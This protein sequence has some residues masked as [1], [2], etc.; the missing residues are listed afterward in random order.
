MGLISRVSSR[1]Y[2]FYTMKLSIFT[3]LFVML[4]GSKANK[5][6][7]TSEKCGALM[8]MDDLTLGDLK[9]KQ[10]EIIKI[11]E[12][13][14]DPCSIDGSIRTFIVTSA[15]SA[16]L[17][18]RFKVDRGSYTLEGLSYDG[19]QYLVTSRSNFDYTVVPGGPVE[20]VFVCKYTAFKNENKVITFNSFSVQI[21]QEPVELREFNGPV[22]QCVGL[23]NQATLIGIFSMLLLIAVV[24][25]AVCMMATISPMD[26]FESPKDRPL[27]VPVD[28]K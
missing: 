6:L 15:S 11:A 19:E 26:R 16:E 24:I 20:S 28:K 23:I 17:Q 22:N 3:I 27:Y 8:F 21:N 5:V 9:S 7:I 1:T 18:I 4:T 2:R 10:S 13:T 25:F 12:A 14:G